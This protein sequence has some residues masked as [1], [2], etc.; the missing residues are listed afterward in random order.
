MAARDGEHY[1]K[2]KQ[3]VYLFAGLLL[4]TQHDG[5]VLTDYAY[6]SNNE[7]TEAG[8]DAFTFDNFGN[9]T[10]IVGVETYS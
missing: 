5:G 9:T 2:V 10:S 4:L 6:G 3:R 8:S 7:M 1:R